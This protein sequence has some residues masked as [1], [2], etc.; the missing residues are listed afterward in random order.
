M[1]FVKFIFLRTRKSR[2]LVPAENQGVGV[3]GGRDDLSILAW[4]DIGPP[5]PK[6]HVYR[7]AEPLNIISLEGTAIFYALL[8]KLLAENEIRKSVFVFRETMWWAPKGTSIN[9][10]PRYLA[11]F[12]LPTYLVLLIN[13]RFWGLFWTPLP[14]LISDVINGHSLPYYDRVFCKTKVFKEVHSNRWM[15]EMY[16]FLYCENLHRFLD[17]FTTRLY[18]M[19]YRLCY[20]SLKTILFWIWKFFF[21]LT[22]VL[23]YSREENNMRKHTCRKVTSSNTCRFFRLLMKGIFDPC[24]LWPFDKKLIS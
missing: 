16:G 2:L 23:N 7:Y 13:I 5:S 9:D 19:Q 4:S 18:V 12:D 20:I 3:I 14:T 1:N 24:A 21:Y 22:K 8:F 15:I 17:F 6:V 10:V 11:I